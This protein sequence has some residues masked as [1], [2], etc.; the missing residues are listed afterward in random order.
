MQIQA[1][2]RTPSAGHNGEN[3][4][5]ELLRRAS[6]GDRSA[7]HRLLLL[8]RTRLAILVL[9]RLGPRTPRRPHLSEVLHEAFVRAMQLQP[10]CPWDSMEALLAWLLPIADG[11]V[12]DVLRRSRN[13]FLDEDRDEEELHP[14]GAHCPYERLAVAV[15]SLS[16]GHR[17]ASSTTSRAYP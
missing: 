16:S 12:E 8:C 3:D 14:A 10:R 5:M 13:P 7:L 1:S 9:L 2:M 15:E 4:E 6:D 11:A 17:E